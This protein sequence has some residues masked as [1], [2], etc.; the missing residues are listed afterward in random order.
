MDADLGREEE[1]LADLRSI[2]G[3]KSVHVVYGVYDIILDVEVDSMDKLKETVAWNIRYAYSE[4]Q[5]AHAQHVERCSLCRTYRD[6]GV[7]LSDLTKE[8]A[9][10]LLN[11]LPGSASMKSGVRSTLTLLV[12]EGSTVQ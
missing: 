12:A 11:P 1:L 10:H 3:V 8:E 4:R 7:T 6:R 9:V 2:P 5:R